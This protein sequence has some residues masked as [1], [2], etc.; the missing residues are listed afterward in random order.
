MDTKGTGSPKHEHSAKDEFMFLIKS[1]DEH[2][3][4]QL[5][6]E[7]Q[8]KT[9]FKD[10]TKALSSLSEF[11]ST[12]L[13]DKKFHDDLFAAFDTVS[14]LIYL[15]TDQRNGIIHNI[16]FKECQERTALYAASE[17]SN[18]NFS[19]YILLKGEIHIFDTNDHFQDL[20]STTTF[21][22]YDG[23]IFHK[24]FNTIV[25]EKDSVI[26]EISDKV[27]LKYLMPFSKFC[28]FI[29]RN[30]IY[31]DKILD[32]LTKIKNFIFNSTDDG[33]VDMEKL[34]SLYKKINPCLHTRATS[35]EFD[36]SS[37]TYALNRLPITVIDTFVFVLLN[38]PPKIIS[39]RQDIADVLIPKVKTTAR[40]RDVFKYLQGKNLVVVREMETDILDF[41]SNMCIH[42]IESRKIR[43][44]INSPI[45][46]GRLFDTRGDFE[47]T[48]EI[49][50]TVTKPEVSNVHKESLKKVFGDDFA[51]KLISLCLHYQDYSINI[52]KVSIGDKDPVECWVQNLWNVAKNLL[53]VNSSVDEI[54][55]LVVDV[56]QGSKRT[57]VSCLSPHIYQHKEEI[58]KWGKENNIPL[59]TKVFLDENDILIAYSYYYYL[60]FPEKQEEKDMELQQ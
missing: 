10:L 30:I 56:V 8:R 43:T 2:K 6:Q 17:P 18:D 45:T 47:K 59:K 55:D 58:L 26:G 46:I 34:L 20:V 39:A 15:N 12:S 27:F 28:T 9:S 52:Q 38:K 25:V 42:I 24:R 35:P 50:K 40:N 1:D 49:F 60:A 51:D 44:V 19:A 16:K 3:I 57:L 5:E 21:F 33:V 22:G 41:L 11:I 4:S 32:D 36:I 31:K 7:Y 23:P 48:F 37:W 13:E 54:D 14:P 29:S 53:G